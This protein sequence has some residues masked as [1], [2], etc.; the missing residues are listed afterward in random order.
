M[1][2]VYNRRRYMEKKRKLK[3]YRRVD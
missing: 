3:K 1:K 2:R